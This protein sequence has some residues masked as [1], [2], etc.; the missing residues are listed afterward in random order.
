M[1]QLLSRVPAIITVGQPSPWV[2]HYHH[3]SAIIIVCQP[4]SLC[5]SHY[6]RV[7][8]IITVCH[9][10]SQRVSHYHR[11]SSIITTGQPL[12]S[13]LASNLSIMC[14]YCNII[15]NDDDVDTLAPLQCI[16][17]GTIYVSIVIHHLVIIIS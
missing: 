5:V 16:S 13:S 11:V 3:V 7:S 6:H 1:G 8:A 14:C 10:L 4:L 12:S 9:P 17:D 2:S 15:N